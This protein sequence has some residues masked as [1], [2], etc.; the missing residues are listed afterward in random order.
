MTK[1]EA[2]KLALEALEADP[3]EMVADANG[4][5]VFL[6]DKAITAI[7][8]AL[9]QP[10]QEP[11]AWEQFHEHMAG[12]FYKAPP[13][14]EKE[15]V[16]WGVFEGNLHDMFFSPS[17]AQEMADLKGTHAEVRPL[18]TTPPQRKP[19]MDEDVE[20]IVREARVGERGIG[21]T[22]ARAIEAAHNIK[23]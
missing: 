2:L 10:E 22:I 13:Q 18:Y 16:A 5:M 17:E 20:R 4:H 14:P 8:E 3:L 6:K 1:D 21:Y 11:V 23:E 15:P 9:A 7:K 19:M 12:P